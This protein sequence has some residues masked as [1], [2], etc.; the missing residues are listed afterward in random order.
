MSSNSTIRT[1]LQ[2]LGFSED[3]A[4]YVTGTCG[5][6]S[7]EDIAYLDGVDDGDTTIK[8]I[9]SPRGTLTTGSGSRLVA[10]RNNGIHVS[11]RTVAKLKL[12]IYYLK[13]M[14]IVQPKPVA[15]TINLVL[16]HSYRDQQIHEVSFKKTAEEPVINDKDWPRTLETI[17]EYLASQYGGT[18]VNLDYVVRPNIAV[19]PEP[20][21]P[22]D[23]YDTVDKDMTARA[24]H[25]G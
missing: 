24:P 8:G 2:R 6:D 1:M 14:E 20:E 17:K 10:S 12:F 9:A 25:T 3:V 21:D 23:G 4:I 22:A 11:I 5:I 7:L 16:V 13:H 19:N 15:N 18:G